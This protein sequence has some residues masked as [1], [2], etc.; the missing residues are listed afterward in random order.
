[1]SP[2]AADFN[3]QITEE[4]RA[5]DGIVG[6]MF[7]GATLLLLHHTGARSGTTYVNPL[8]YLADDGRYVIFASAAGAPQHPA[9]Y[10]NLKAD[11]K[12]QIEVGTDTLDVVATEATG[13][14]R[15]RLYDAQSERSAAFIEYQKKAGRVI[16]VM[17]LTP[18]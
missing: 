8:V 12:V 18:A 7:E 16:P 15:D 5:N 2:S 13:E 17:I 14:E 9:W 4:F 1:M 6:G 11:P 3:A 10:H